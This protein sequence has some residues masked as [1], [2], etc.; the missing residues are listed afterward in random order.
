MGVL[1]FFVEIE[2]RKIDLKD[3]HGGFITLE[4]GIYLIKHNSAGGQPPSGYYGQS[5]FFEIKKKD[6]MIEVRVE[7]YPAI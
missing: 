4:P 1:T 7:L 3:L 6:E 5:S 2:E